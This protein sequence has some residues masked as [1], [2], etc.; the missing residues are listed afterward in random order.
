MNV[1]VTGTGLH[2]NF[3]NIHLPFPVIPTVPAAVYTASKVV[4][5]V[6]ITIKLFVNA[7]FDEPASLAIK[8]Y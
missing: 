8:T 5:T 2:L 6:V 3:H 1:G 7:I 4:Q